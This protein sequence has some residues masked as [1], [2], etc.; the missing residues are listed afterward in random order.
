MQCGTVEPLWNNGQRTTLTAATRPML[1][2]VVTSDLVP[3]QVKDDGMG[4][5]RQSNKHP[6]ACR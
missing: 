3:R 4:T 2:L 1:L 6:N 5:K